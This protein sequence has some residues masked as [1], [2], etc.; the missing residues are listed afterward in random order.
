M[1][2]PH[3]SVSREA[4]HHVAGAMNHH[5]QFGGLVTVPRPPHR[6]GESPRQASRQGDAPRQS[7][8]LSEPPRP[9]SA[10]RQAPQHVPGAVEHQQQLCGLGDAPRPPHRHGEPPWQDFFRGEAPRQSSGRS[11]PPRPPLSSF[12][13]SHPSS[14]SDYLFFLYQEVGTAGQDGT[15]ATR[16][17]SGAR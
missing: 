5:Q 7:S 12:F 8:P 17:A 16:M 10:T 14:F 6:H 9:A 13:S 11:E 4:P 3:A 2:P 15:G 1:L